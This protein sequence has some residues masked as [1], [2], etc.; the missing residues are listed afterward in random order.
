MSSSY[1]AYLPLAMLLDHWLVFIPQQPHE[2]CVC[3]PTRTRFFSALRAVAQNNK[4]DLRESIGPCGTPGRP[5]GLA[6]SESI[7]PCGTPG[8]EGRAGA[9]CY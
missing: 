8:R 6:V 1:F 3:A 9:D 5:G 4:Y 7:S 2:R